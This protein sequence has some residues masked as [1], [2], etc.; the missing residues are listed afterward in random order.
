MSFTPSKII[1]SSQQGIHSNL[2]QVVGKHLTHSYRKPITD[3]NQHAF[4]KARDY[5]NKLE[6]PSV[7]LDS[8]CGTAESTRF[9]ST[10]YKDSLVIG[11]DQ[12]A[13]RLANSQNE[14]LAEN[15]I[16]LRC[17][18]TDFWRLAQQTKWLFEKH[19]LLYPNPYPK[20]P[21]F[22]RRWHGHPA[23]PSLLA[24]S[25]KI[26]LR[27]NWRL[28]AEEFVVALKI[29]GYQ[30]MFNQYFSDTAITAFERKY[31]LSEH[32]LWQVSCQIVAGK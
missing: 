19:Y 5:W 17:D 22:Q 4:D 23:F 30:A 31:Q 18:C 13:K 10:Q 27:T 21:H 12:S 14:S 6:Q 28:Y 29:A 24:I 9:L 25:Q 11:L 7:I 32:P 1:T 3:Y 20:P 2:E 16:L 15:A 26:E 8:A